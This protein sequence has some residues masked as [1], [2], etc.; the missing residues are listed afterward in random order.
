MIINIDGTYL[1]SYSV[2]DY[3]H[4]AIP[5]SSSEFILHKEVTS[6]KDKDQYLLYVYSSTENKV[7][8]QFLNLD[9]FLSEE[10]AFSP[11]TSLYNFNDTICFF[12][13]CSDTVYNVFREKV[14][15]RYVINYPMKKEFMRI[16]FNKKLALMEFDDEIKK[17]GLIMNINNFFEG[18]RFVFF[19]YF[20][21]GKV[22]LNFYDKTINHCNTFSMF[23][24]D[25]I[26]GFGNAYIS[27]LFYPIYVD[28]THMYFVLEAYYIISEFK[29]LKEKQP[30]MWGKAILKYPEANALLNELSY[31]SNPVILKY[32]FKT[33]N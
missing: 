10:R 25:I 5:I 17:M 29:K 21:N 28:N 18:N 26:L 1:N 9:P 32:K 22:F 11:L 24:E 2:N 14:E 27:E 4:D 15:P 8:N 6:G 7:T 33:K 19:T 3:F 31:A 16:Y 20:Q 23:K 13:V 12:Q 30:E